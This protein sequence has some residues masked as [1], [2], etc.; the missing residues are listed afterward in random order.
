MMVDLQY[1]PAGLN[2]VLSAA[3]VLVCVCRLDKIRGQ[4][5]FRVSMQYVVM[6]MAAG[7]NGASPWL[8]DLPGWPSVFF[9]GAVLFM[10]CADSYQWRTGPPESATGPAPLSEQ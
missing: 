8:F 5:L 4:V 10:L 1:L 2:G 7:A 6:V 9:A 3:I